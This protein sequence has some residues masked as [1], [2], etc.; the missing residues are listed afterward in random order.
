MAYESDSLTR[1][2]VGPALA[3]AVMGAVLGAVG[4]VGIAQLSGDNTLPQDSAQVSDDAL[5]G[6]VEYGSRN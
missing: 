4:V 1:R 3:A 2:T 5:L 6:G